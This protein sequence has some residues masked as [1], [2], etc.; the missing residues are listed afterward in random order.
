MSGVVHEHWWYDAQAIPRE[1]ASFN[2]FD[3]AVQYVYPLT[4]EKLD[5]IAPASAS[6][7]SVVNPLARFTASCLDRVLA[8]VGND[9][10]G[11]GSGSGS[12]SGGGGGGGEGGQ[13]QSIEVERQRRLFESAE[14][15]LRKRAAQGP[16][17]PPRI[18][19]ATV[20]IGIGQVMFAGGCGAHPHDAGHGRDSGFYESVV[21]YDSLADE[22]TDL[23]C[24][25][26]KRHG[27]AAVRCGRKVYVLGEFV[28]YRI[29]SHRIASHRIASH[30]VASHRVAWDRTSSHPTGLPTYLPT[31]QHA[32]CVCPCM[33]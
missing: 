8:V 22:W 21:Q 25:N 24:M 32:P 5:N 10:G 12:G 17:P 2:A 28:S 11:G 26:L 6:A 23:P 9:D 20:D 33:R 1:I 29:A 19:C 4:L 27:A 31:L 15:F 3:H 13:P 18:D 16:R 30:R 7:S 14:T